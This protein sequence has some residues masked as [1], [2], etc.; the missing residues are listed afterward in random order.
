MLVGWSHP[1]EQKFLFHRKSNSDEVNE[2]I[3][4]WF[5]RAQAMWRL[6]HESPLLIFRRRGRDGSSFA[7]ISF[8][9]EGGR[10]H[11]LILSGGKSEDS[12]PHHYQILMV[13]ITQSR[14][15]RKKMIASFFSKFG[16]ST[17]CFGP[18]VP[19]TIYLPKIVIYGVVKMRLEFHALPNIAQ[20]TRPF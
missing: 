4:K 20:Q 16:P 5:K 15:V 1:K 3:R 10:G 11:G 19:T 14:S 17:C 18:S 13:N 7:L 6:I 9:K 12:A 2:R 8:D